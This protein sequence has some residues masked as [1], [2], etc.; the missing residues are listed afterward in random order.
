MCVAWARTGFL[1]S[2][3]LESL[4]L[5][6]DFCLGILHF[7]R[8]QTVWTE[9]QRC[10]V[11]LD[12][13]DFN[14]VSRHAPSPCLTLKINDFRDHFTWIAIL[15]CMYIIQELLKNYFKLSTQ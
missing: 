6:I 11:T 2:L 10:F 1:L 12:I 15:V 4:H 8:K 5:H 7:L 9:T 3:C 13:V 14:Y